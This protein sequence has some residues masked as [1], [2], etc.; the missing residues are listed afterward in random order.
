MPSTLSSI[1]RLARTVP[2]QRAPRRQPNAGR[3][4]RLAALRVP[5][6]TKLIG[7]NLLVVALLLFAWLGTGGHVS[8]GVIAVLGAFVLLHLTLIFVALRPIRDLEEVA[9]RVWHGDFG[10]RVD[11][12]AV[13]DND[14]LRIGSMFNVLLDGLE[15]DREKM[16]A[17]ATEVIAVG[18]RERAALARELHDSTAQRLAALLL[19]LSAAAR[20]CR[21]AALRDRLRQARD[22][23]EELTEEVRLLSHTLHP[24]VLDDLGLVAALRKLARDS[25]SMTRV[26]VDVDVSQAEVQVSPQDAAV[27]YRVAQEAV[28]NAVRHA[29]PS[30]VQ[31][32]L[33]STPASAELEVLDDGVGFDPEAVA[34]AGAGL[35]LL[36]MRERVALADGSLQIISRRGRGTKVHARVPLAGA[37]ATRTQEKNA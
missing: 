26:P 34:A 18:D 2:L 32:T 24:R 19:Q 16:R 9:S 12:S 17:L 25:V 13:A 29:A 15:S 36:S 4:I 14:V 7:A 30:H 1:P 27:L 28:R 11:H 22:S 6:A 10:A 5:L 20:D 3:T 21:D 37:T 31:V 8:V 33:R 35:G 23:A